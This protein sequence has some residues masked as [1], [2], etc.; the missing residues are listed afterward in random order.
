MDNRLQFEKRIMQRVFKVSKKH[1]VNFENAMK[2]KMSRLKKNAVNKLQKKLDKRQEK[3][4]KELKKQEDEKKKVFAKFYKMSYNEM[5]QYAKEKNI[6]IWRKTREEIL[7][8][9]IEQERLR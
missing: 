6:K 1:R 8:L 7:E 2:E 3:N 9:L 4:K 5:R